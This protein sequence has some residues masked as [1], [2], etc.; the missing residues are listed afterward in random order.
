MQKELNP[1]LFGEKSATRSRQLS[2]NEATSGSQG[3]PVI[4]FEKRLAELRRDLQDSV[5]QTARLTQQM[6]EFSQTCQAH[7]DRMGKA[8]Q[9]LE[10]SQQGLALETNQKIGQIGLKIGER[11]SLDA[12]VQEMVDRHQSVLRSYEV[13]LANLQKLISEREQQVHSATSALHEAKMELARLKR[14]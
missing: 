9:T 8:L 2:G 6:R 1:D 4:E 7:F 13:R 14:L 12:K 5:Q 11:K 3:F 10:R